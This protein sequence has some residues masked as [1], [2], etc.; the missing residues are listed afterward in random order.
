MNKEIENKTR[1]LVEIRWWVH[2]Q[3]QVKTKVKKHI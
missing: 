1:M 3:L 2:W